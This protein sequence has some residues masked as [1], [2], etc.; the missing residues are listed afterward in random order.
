MDYRGWQEAIVCAGAGELLVEAVEGGLGSFV[1]GEEGAGGGERGDD[2]GGDAL[3]EAAE[4]GGLVE[5]VG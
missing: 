3:V 4:E 5:G 2:D 1:G